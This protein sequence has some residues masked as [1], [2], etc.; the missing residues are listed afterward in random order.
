MHDAHV[1]R[2]VSLNV[3]H[4]TWARPIPPAAVTALLSLQP[5][6]LVLVEYVEGHGRPELRAALHDAG[7]SH[8]ASSDSLL[9]RG[10]SA[11]W[12]QVFIASRWPIEVT[13]D[14]TGLHPCNGCGFLSVTTG[15]LALTGVRVPMWKSAADWYG[16]WEE[17]LPH[18]QGDL[19]IGDLNI[20]P[21]RCRRRDQKP[22]KL[23]GEAGW[24]HASAEGSW[25][26]RGRAGVTSSVDHVFVRGEV[27]VV[28]ARYGAEGI[29][30]VGPLD[31]AAL[32]VEGLHLPTT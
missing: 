18:F 4:Q 12:N 26:Y 25:S 6:I 2:I 11:W 19:L 22:L 28:S 21:S 27:E 9:Y 30:G 24:R 16:A 10:K 15:G 3:G 1:P 7:L 23:L 31:H 13:S 17:M 8:T 14:R 5:D 32:V 20:D 29:A